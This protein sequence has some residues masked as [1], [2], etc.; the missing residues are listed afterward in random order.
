MRWNLIMEEKNKPGWYCPSPAQSF[1]KADSSFIGPPSPPGWFWL[2][3]QIHRTRHGG[4]CLGDASPAPGPGPPSAHSLWIKPA[5]DGFA[6]G[7]GEAHCHGQLPPST[8]AAPWE[9]GCVH[10]PHLLCFWLLTQCLVHNRCSVIAFE[11]ITFLWSSQLSMMVLTSLT[12]GQ[13]INEPSD[14]V[15]KTAS[16]SPLLG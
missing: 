6:L 9:H 14:A 11:W 7:A 2:S 12:D 3:L 10:V 16:A 15:T 1:C 13:D 5:H 4:C 8:K